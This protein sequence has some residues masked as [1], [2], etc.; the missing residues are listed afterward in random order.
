[1]MNEWIVDLTEF[2]LVLIVTIITYS[3]FDIYRM[4]R[5]NENA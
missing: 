3:V 5:T 1:M 2:D 4:R